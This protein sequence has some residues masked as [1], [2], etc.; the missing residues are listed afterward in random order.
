LTA[1]IASL[2]LSWARRWK[3]HSSKGLFTIGKS[4]LGR[5]QLRG[6]NLVPNPPASIKAFS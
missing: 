2:M 4:V 3:I 1:N 5:V 6:L